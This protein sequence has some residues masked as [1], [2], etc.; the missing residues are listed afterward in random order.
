MSMFNLQGEKSKDKGYFNLSDNLNMPVADTPGK[1]K[2]RLKTIKAF[3]WIDHHIT[4]QNSIGQQ[5]E[6]RR[7]ASY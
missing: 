1:E 3:N 7:K 5:T 4:P 6:Q 2:H